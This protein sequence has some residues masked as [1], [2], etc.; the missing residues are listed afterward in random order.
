MLL[1]SVLCLT[2]CR[3]PGFDEATP[4]LPG[5]CG[6]EGLPW[7]VLQAD[8]SLIPAIDEAIGY[9]PDLMVRERWHSIDDCRDGCRGLITVW[10]TEL[11]PN[12][13]GDSAQA[14]EEG[15][16]VTCEV[17]VNST[18]PLDAAV[19]AHEFGHC[20]GLDHSPNEDSV[21]HDP[22]LPGAVATEADLETAWGD[23]CGES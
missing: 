7:S 17:R 15:R 16:I 3:G 20:L 22:P 19:L 4:R 12:V 1:V 9:W 21:M 23:D 18:W 6:V 11:D 8:D 2:A 14:V 10:P 5:V 13:L